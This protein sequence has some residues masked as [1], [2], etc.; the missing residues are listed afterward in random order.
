MVVQ[1]QNI[2]KP[3]A[4]ALSELKSLLDEI[5][6]TAEYEKIH[7]KESKKP[8][9]NSDASRLNRQIAIEKDNIHP[10]ASLMYQVEN[11]LQPYYNRQICDA[12][13]EMVKLLK[14]AESLSV[15]KVKQVHGYLQKIPLLM[16]E[17]FSLYEKTVYEIKIA[18][19]YAKSGHLVAFIDTEEKRTAD[20][21]VD[22]CVEIECKKK[23]TILPVNRSNADSWNI[24][25]RKASEAM[26]NY[27]INYKFTV[28]S[29]RNLA[30]PEVKIINEEIH[31]IIAHKK[32]GTF[33]LPNLVCTIDAEILLPYDKEIESPISA[34]GN[35]I[36]CSDEFP[37]KIADFFKHH[38]IACNTQ[39]IRNTQYTAIT[40]NYRFFGFK[41]GEPKS[42]SIIGSIRDAAGQIS[43]NCPGIVYID[44]DRINRGMKQQDLNQFNTTISNQLRFSTK[45]SVLVITAEYTT[46]NHGRAEFQQGIFVVR[47]PNAKIK[48]KDSFEIPRANLSSLKTLTSTG[49]LD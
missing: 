14:I 3:Y 11:S 49:Y 40:K 38:Q 22:N 25:M 47:N 33:E 13:I 17:D 48:I 35:N 37:V 23:D 19:E 20:I 42:R 10:L 39:L 16:S 32:E 9:N 15:L 5:W 30:P 41:S 4:E 43:E 45:I 24:M 27:K 2:L 34:S 44:L 46:S 36:V 1:N 21:I 8:K 29:E 28:D 7:H 26:D 31:K 6:L 12:T 18:G